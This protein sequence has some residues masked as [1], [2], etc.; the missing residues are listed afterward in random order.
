MHFS[1]DCPP[2]RDFV[3]LNVTSSSFHASW[4]LNSFQN[5]TFHVQVYKGREALSGTW[6]RAQT[7]AVSDLEAG[8][9]YRVR[10]SYQGC[11]ANV[12]ATLAVKTGKV[13]VR[14]PGFLEWACLSQSSGTLAC[15][16]I[17]LECRGGGLTTYPLT[18]SQWA[19]CCMV[20]TCMVLT[21]APCLLTY[22]LCEALL[23][24]S[25]AYINV[26]R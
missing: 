22:K 3:A 10:V 21:R 12:S 25:L 6:T 20:L 8:V 9:L 13:L 23:S 19:K 11:Q 7:L 26:V 15:H 2:I 24:N 1:P 18:I 5:H 17:L 14:Q 16:M 4:N